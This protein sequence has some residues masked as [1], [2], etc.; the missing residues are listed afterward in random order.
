MRTSL[1]HTEA[2][3]QLDKSQLLQ[4]TAAGHKWIAEGYERALQFEAPKLTRSIHE[5]VVCSV[6]GG[7]VASLVQ[8][9][10]LVHDR[11]RV[12]VILSQAYSMPAYVDEDS[13]VI[14]VNYS[15]GSEEIVSAYEHAAK[16]GAFILV[17]SAG[18]KAKEIAAEHG[19][20]FYA[21]PEGRVP[22][23]IST[24]HVLV[25]LLV[26]LH[27]MGLLD[28]PAADIAETAA[29]L[30]RLSDQYGA[31][32]PL[33]RNAAKQIAAEMDG[34]IPVIYGTLPFTDAAALRFKNQLAEN[35][36][37]MAFA[38][39]MSALHHDEAYGWDADSAMLRQFHFTLL[40]DREDSPAM[41]KRI[42]ATRDVLRG[43]AGGVRELASIGE[44]RL[45]RLCS[46]VHTID[47]VTLYTALI[48]GVNPAQSDALN[49]FR[50]LYTS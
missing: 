44:S 9:K 48:R 15:G 4:A 49:R 12:P 7:P 34:L 31:E 39:A 27:Q 19:H 46:L 40:R 36:K 25:P 28:D 26:I 6:G 1:D 2:L 30:E 5:I 33:E 3:L 17:M 21:L 41:S 35:G 23:I 13:L 18:G 38:N 47:F 10:S 37:V 50:K 42:A 43:Q 20:S 8:L 11:L 22:R 45:A 14:V 32:V 24:G 16:T 29:L